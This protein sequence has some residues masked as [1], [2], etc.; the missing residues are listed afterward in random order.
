MRTRRF[1]WLAIP[2]ILLGLCLAPADVLAKKPGGGGGGPPCTRNVWANTPSIYET[3][4]NGDDTSLRLVVPAS[5]EEVT[6]ARFQVDAS[7][8]RGNIT[9]DGFLFT[10]LQGAPGGIQFNVYTLSTGLNCYAR[11]TNAPADFSLYG[12]V[13]PTSADFSVDNVGTPFTQ[14][15][16]GS[17]LCVYVTAENVAAQS[18]DLFQLG[19]DYSYTKGS[20]RK[21]LNADCLKYQDHG[22]SNDKS[23]YDY[24]NGVEGPAPARTFVE[25]VV[26]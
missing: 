7:T 20:N 26:Q 23:F 14:D 9:V 4:D 11:E 25:F 16:L 6:V 1:L 5:G 17:H 15:V 2:L 18:G 8:I 19:I 3:A 22:L 21:A 13:L 12:S 10:L 24:R